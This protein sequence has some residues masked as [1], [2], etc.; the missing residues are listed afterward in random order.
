M[1]NVLGNVLTGN[2]WDFLDKQITLNLGFMIKYL[3]IN[4]WCS[5]TFRWKQTWETKDRTWLYS[6]ISHMTNVHKTKWSLYIKSKL[7]YNEKVLLSGENSIWILFGFQCFMLLLCWL[8]HCDITVLLKRKNLLP[9]Q[10]LKVAGI[11]TR[12][13]SSAKNK[14]KEQNETGMVLPDADKYTICL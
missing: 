13:S 11:V 5:P 2:N 7:N 8:S 12:S 6:C 14:G 1:K 10:K 4:S 9:L 3:L